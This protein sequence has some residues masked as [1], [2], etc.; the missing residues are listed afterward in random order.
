LTL[1]EHG[2]L[3]AATAQGMAMAPKRA[4]L[5][6]FGATALVGIAGLLA[7]NQVVIV[8]VNEGLQ[9]V[10]F[11]GLRS[12]LA[13]GFVALWLWAR[14]R[15]AR[16]TPGTA[17]A[18][19]LIGT[20]FAAE[21]LC[22][23]LALDLTAISRAVLIFYTM[24]VWLALM[25]HVWLPGERLTPIR[26]LGLVL[27]F[28]GTATAILDRSHAGTGTASLTG[29]LCALGGA[30]GWAGTAFLTKVTAMKRVGP[31]MQLFWMV[32]V[33]APVLLVASLFFGPLIRDL[34]PIHLVWLTFQASVVVAG[35]FIGWLWLLSV[36]PAATV[37]SFSFLTPVLSLGLGWLVL[38]EPLGPAIIVAAVLVAVGIVL[39]NRR[40]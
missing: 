16:Y 35:G 12:A 24:P 15:P 28:A 39:I 18:G 19:V 13:T 7:F 17:A 32:A 1:P 30:L 22:L 3:V 21:F 29:D 2:L 34:Q 38:D 8:W 14:R 5:D 9:P 20:V 33:S 36:Y 26:T 11:A 10:F 27:A 6:T 40:V 23:F 4:R 37:A 25:A 31:E